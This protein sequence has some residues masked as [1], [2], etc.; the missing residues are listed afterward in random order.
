MSSPTKNG[1]VKVFSEFKKQF[2]S[3]AMVAGP[4]V[5]KKFPPRG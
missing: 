5:A 3:G 2:S 4:A 1:W